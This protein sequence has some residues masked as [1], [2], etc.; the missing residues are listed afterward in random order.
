MCSGQG[1]CVLERDGQN[2]VCQCSDNF[3]GIDCSKRNAPLTCSCVTLID[4][5]CHQEIVP[6]H[7]ARLFVTI[8]VPVSRPLGFVAVRMATTALPVH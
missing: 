6:N 3:F 8:T 4:C 7:L 2:S 1:E 5:N